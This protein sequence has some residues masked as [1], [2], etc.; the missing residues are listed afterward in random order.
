MRWKKDE[1]SESFGGNNQSPIKSDDKK[2]KTKR[3]N[4]RRKS[5]EVV[6]HE[7]RKGRVGG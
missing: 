3:G 2:K 7:E 4:E 6:G 5:W 1:N